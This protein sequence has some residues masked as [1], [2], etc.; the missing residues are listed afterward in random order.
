[1]KKSKTSKKKV[2]RKKTVAEARV[3]ESKR[4]RTSG[5]KVRPPAQKK[6]SSGAA[7]KEIRSPETSTL[8]GST[9]ITAQGPRSGKRSRASGQ[10]GDGQGLS[11]RALADSES[12]EE[13]VEEGQ[14][15][16]ASAISG[17][18]EALD[19]DEAEVRTRQ[20]PEDDVPEEYTDED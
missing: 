20:V 12:V 17:V 5:K 2:A 16:E 8:G 15:R 14:A 7:L 6:R 10:S 13:L 19:P 18:E 1:M 11:E 4:R 9:F 3:K